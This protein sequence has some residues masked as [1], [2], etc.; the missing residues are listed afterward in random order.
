MHFLFCSLPFLFRSRELGAEVWWRW[1]GGQEWVSSVSPSEPT[2]SA[3]NLNGLVLVL[4]VWIKETRLMDFPVFA[5]LTCKS[6]AKGS[7]CWQTFGK[8][9]SVW[10]RLST[11]LPICM[12][13]KVHTWAELWCVSCLGIYLINLYLT[14]PPMHRFKRHSLDPI[15]PVA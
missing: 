14:L 9:A 1:V 5:A 2:T 10:H 3:S 4:E 6:N 7:Y 11:L 8:Q 12:A 15:K 13:L